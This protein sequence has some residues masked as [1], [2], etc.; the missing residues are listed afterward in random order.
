MMS[1]SSE[2]MT[3]DELEFDDDLSN[4]EPTHVAYADESRHNTGRYRAVALVTLGIDDAQ[5]AN[6]ELQKIWH[7]LNIR[8]FKWT[9]LKSAHYRFAALK[10]VDRVMSWI[11]GRKV[12]I[13]V[14]TW[15]T[16]DTRH[17][18]RNRSDMRNLRRMYYYE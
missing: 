4:A 9:K 10:M 6:N 5:H 13:D 3:M 12:R 2:A 7:E 17:T 11:D 1:F 14:I 8:E 15:D 18:V 16:E